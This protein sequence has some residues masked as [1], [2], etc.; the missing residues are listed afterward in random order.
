GE[1]GDDA[2]VAV[3]DMGQPTLANVVSGDATVR[4]GL[5]T[6]QAWV[7]GMKPLDILAG[8]ASFPRQATPSRSCAEHLVDAAIGLA[9]V[10]SAFR[11]IRRIEQ[12]HRAIESFPE[13]G[14]RPQSRSHRRPSRATHVGRDQGR[15]VQKPLQLGRL[16]MNELGAEFDGSRRV[17][18]PDGEYAAADA[19][20][21]FED[22][23]VDAG[24]MQRTGGGKSGRARTDHYDHKTKCTPRAQSPE[25]RAQS[26]E[27]R[28]Q[29]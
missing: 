6:H 24:L 13:A 4:E 18:I 23:D 20:A 2:I 11:R 29:S 22:L 9:P 25:P 5:R 3:D 19:I 15:L 16:A 12:T 28:A 7:S 1:P 27:P 8:D 21:G 10:V 17:G 26:P 14:Q